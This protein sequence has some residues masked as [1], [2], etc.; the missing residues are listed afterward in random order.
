MDQILDRASE[1]A[2]TLARAGFDGVLVENY[3][4]LPFHKGRAPSE[5]VAATAVAVREVRR[6]C[7]IPV[8]VNVLRNDADAALA[9]ASSTGAAFMRVN[10]HTGSMFTDQGLIQGQAHWTLRKREMLK[11]EVSILADVMVKHAT[12]PPGVT[13]EE[14]ARDAWFRGMADGV[15]LTGWE[16]GL[17]VDLEEVR[18]VKEALSPNGKVWVGSGTTKETA[19]KLLE[20]ADGLIVGSDLQRGGVAGEGVDPDR[21][22]AFMEGLGR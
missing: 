22:R 3:G 8:G 5:T 9:V 4:D 1:E 20:A 12:P 7:A 21:L 2:T 15:I 18:R 13:L 11:L 16:T 17:S 19:R 6:S 10:V 14:A